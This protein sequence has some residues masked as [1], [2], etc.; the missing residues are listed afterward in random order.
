MKCEFDSYTDIGGR[1]NNEDA[2]CYEEKRDSYL[3]AVADGLGGHDCGEIASNIAISEI[4]RQF[5]EYTDFS[6]KQAIFDANKL[7]LEKQYESKKKMKTTVVAVHIGN[8][9]TTVVNV[10]DSRAYF[11]LD[12]SI[13][14]QTTDHSVSQLAVKLGEITADQ[15]R[16]HEDRNILT[17][18]LGSSETLKI[19]ISELE[20][21]LFDRVL[22][23]SDG[24]WEYVLE[25]EICDTSKTSKNPEAWLFKMRE[26]HAKRI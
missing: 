3:F 1:K 18:A 21:D 23:C 10:G 26:R 2:L 15:I 4:K 8:R 14:F 17:R 5:T 13:K 9:K 22:I 12:H 11:L 24:F 20:N 25:D 19:D 7:I 16:Y 6:L